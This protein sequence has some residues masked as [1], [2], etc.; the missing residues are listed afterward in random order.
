MNIP[1]HSF[2]EN[3]AAEVPAPDSCTHLTGADHIASLTAALRSLDSQL[4]TLDRWGRL[5][6]DVPAGRTAAGCSRPATGQRRPG[7]APD[8]RAGRPLPGRPAAVLR[9]SA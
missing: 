4:D 2:R 7:P 8:R 3:I 6:A 1:P 5:I 9:R